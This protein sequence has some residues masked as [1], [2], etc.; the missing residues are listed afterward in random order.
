MSINIRVLYV[1]IGLQYS[2]CTKR[3]APNDT[4]LAGLVWFRQRRWQAA[5]T[6]SKQSHTQR[7]PQSRSNPCSTVG[8]RSDHA[9]PYNHRGPRSLGIPCIGPE[10]TC[11]HHPRLPFR[12]ILQPNVAPCPCYSRSPRSTSFFSG[13]LYHSNLVRVRRGAEEKK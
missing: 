8:N 1:I 3:N 13:L 12:F 10:F 7:G 2:Y 6:K 5:S 11:V 9:S 4:Q